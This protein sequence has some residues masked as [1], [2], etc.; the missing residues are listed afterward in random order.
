MPGRQNKKFHL[1]IL[2]QGPEEFLADCDK[3]IT[4]TEG[5]QSG[6]I[7]TNVGEVQDLI[8]E[9][10]QSG[11]VITIELNYPSKETLEKLGLQDVANELKKMGK[12]D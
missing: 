11:E 1:I 9:G 12:L 6:G 4:I 8:T 10:P 5:L 2:V 3:V 7:I